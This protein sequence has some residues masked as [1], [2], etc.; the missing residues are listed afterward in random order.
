MQ[1]EICLFHPHGRYFL[2]WAKNWFRST[3]KSK[4]MSIYGN[5]S[6]GFELKFY[7]DGAFIEVDQSFFRYIQVQKKCNYYNFSPF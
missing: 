5:F 2:F 4:V 3:I 1:N 7:N 6:K